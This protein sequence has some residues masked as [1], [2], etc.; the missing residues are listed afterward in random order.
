MP[1]ILGRRRRFWLASAAASRWSPAVQ[2]FGSALASFLTATL[3]G[4]N[5]GDAGP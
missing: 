3:V 1:T 5:P 2:A 4:T